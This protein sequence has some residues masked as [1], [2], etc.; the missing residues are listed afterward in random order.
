M[1]LPS[2][3][4]LL[5]EVLPSS[6]PALL[7]VDLPSAFPKSL[8]RQISGY[9]SQQSSDPV[10]SDTP[11]DAEQQF[12][13]QG[14]PKRKKIVKGPWWNVR[15]GSECGVRRSLSRRKKIRNFDSGVWMGS[16]SSEE[17]N[18]SIVPNQQRTQMGD[19][20][21]GENAIPVT[22]A[23]A[24]DFIQR[25]LD[26]GKEAVD[27]T[28]LGLYN[29]SNATLRPLHQLIRHSHDQ[30]TQP[31][32]EDEFVPLTPSLQLFL[33]NNHISS[34]PAELFTFTNLTVLSLRSNE[35]SRLPAAIGRLQNLQELNVSG[36]QL[37]FLP[38]EML[39]LFSCQQRHREITVRPNPFFEP[40]DMT[41]Q[42]SRTSLAADRSSLPGTR[43]PSSSNQTV[44][45]GSCSGEPLDGMR[46]EMNAR[47]Q[48]ARKSCSHETMTLSRSCADEL[49]HLASSRIRYFAV[50]G[51]PV[52]PFVESQDEYCAVPDP[53]CDARQSVPVSRVPSLY[54][55]ALRSLQVNFDIQDTAIL[56]EDIT[57]PQGVVDSVKSA[58]MNVA[59][60]GNDNCSSCQRQMILPRARWVEY[61]YHG[62]PSEESLTRDLVIPFLR[63]ACSWACANP[64]KVGTYR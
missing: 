51:T 48:H 24:A 35:L 30:L 29:I 15:R 60:F 32:S 31:P 22:E 64:T 41:S 18:A 63:V 46:E 50:D 39:E 37:K 10:F 8:K 61:W 9:A 4:P 55:L 5:P 59:E 47:L 27:L 42:T 1:A 14:D 34:L 33:A 36:N 21:V 56:Q 38:W 13:E 44:L 17:S 45:P 52:L 26:E 43:I 19:A 23:I 16:D 20:P 49:I 58:A 54:E 3:P 12:D 40:V 7:S 57:V 28:D 53:M 25:C 11:S 2:S 6:P 62:S